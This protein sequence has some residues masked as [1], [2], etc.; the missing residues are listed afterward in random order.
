M[1]LYAPWFGSGVPEFPISNH[2]AT[3]PFS[4]FIMKYYPSKYVLFTLLEFIVN[5]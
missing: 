3:Y 4:S 2:T 5:V 1:L